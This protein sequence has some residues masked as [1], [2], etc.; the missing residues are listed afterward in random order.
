MTS[1]PDRQGIMKLVNEALQSGASQVQICATLGISARTLQ[2]WR[3]AGEGGTDQR[4]EAS[5]RVPANALSPQEKEAVLEL[6]NQPEYASKCPSQIVPMLADMGEYLA[7][8]S[9][10]YRILRAQNQQH[11][12]GKARAPKA[13]PK[14]THHATAP[15]QVWVWDITWLPT[16]VRG[17]FYRLYVIMDL[18]SRKIIA[19]EVW[20][21][22]NDER[23]REL[24]KRACLNEGVHDGHALVLHGDNGSPLKSANIHTLMTWLG[25]TPSHSRPRVSNDN[26][27]AESLF[28]TLKYHP[29]LPE[30]PFESLGQARL[31]THRFVEWY[32]HEHRHCSINFV[33]PH[34]KHL[35]LDLDIL[36]KRKL[37]YERARARNPLRWIRKKT[38]NCNPVLITSLNPDDPRQTERILKKSA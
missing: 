17:L 1:A 30:K 5:R 3:N 13:R 18:Y 38:R 31:W 4:C 26:A 32:N 37:T 27:H 35:G 10:I 34:Q 14:A 20:E 12:R 8:E 6:C 33:T 11:H 21:E 2:R 29:S 19:W 25:V 7:S 22:E 16:K 9:S 28:R 24:L 15:R 23:A 36:K